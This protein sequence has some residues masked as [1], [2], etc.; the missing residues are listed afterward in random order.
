MRKIL[1]V[2]AMLPLCACVS[3]VVG[4]AVGVTGAVAGAAI[5]TTGA[6]V[7]AGVH[8]ITP[9]GKK[10]HDNDDSDGHR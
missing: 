2:L 3:T 7:G 10:D 1:V 9:H 5:H 8:A 4:T 6:V